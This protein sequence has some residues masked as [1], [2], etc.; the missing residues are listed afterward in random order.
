M[1]TACNYF[2][3]DD[4]PQLSLESFKNV[5][6]HKHMQPIGPHSCPFCAD[7]GAVVFTRNSV[8]YGGREYGAWPWC[9][10][11]LTCDAYVGCHPGTVIP[12][13]TLADQKTLNARKE[14]HA[15]FDPL[16]RDGPFT[17][18]EAYKYLAEQL[19]IQREDCHISW[20]GVDECKRVVD[21]ALA[22]NKTPR[23]TLGGLF[24]NLPFTRRRR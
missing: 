4:Q 10:F 14:A 13:G 7:G 18:K 11:C 8:K 21:V 12:L 23:P 16:W 3:K 5:T 24:D 15:A 1:L 6:K 2:D 20:F 19:G 17:R 9:Y 22:H